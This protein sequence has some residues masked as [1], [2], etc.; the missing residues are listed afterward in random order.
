[1]QRSIALVACLLATGLASA[2]QNNPISKGCTAGDL[3]GASAGACLE[4]NFGA[5][6]NEVWVVTCDPGGGQHYCCHGTT[7][8]G[9]GISYDC[10]PISSDVRHLPTNAGIPVPVLIKPN[11]AWCPASTKPIH[12]WAVQSGWCV[13]GARKEIF[14]LAP[15]PA[16]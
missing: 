2:A 4:K 1:M 15:G 9:G 7:N 8:A 10:E 12:N 16:K 11:N 5:G 3:A 14:T 13:D 6:D